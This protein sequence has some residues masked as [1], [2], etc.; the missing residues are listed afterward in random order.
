MSIG[1]PHEVLPSHGVRSEEQRTPNQSFEVRATDSEAA[2]HARATDREAVGLRTP[3]LFVS[4]S[5]H[6][7]VVK[8]VVRPPLVTIDAGVRERRV[9]VPAEREDRLVHLLGVEDPES[10]E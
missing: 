1:G 3:R 5:R 8:P 4:V 2:C 10:H 9:L 6:H 7:R